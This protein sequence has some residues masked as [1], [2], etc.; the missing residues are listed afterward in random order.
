MGETQIFSLEHC[1][2]L[3]W[4]TFA[5]MGNTEEGAGLGEGKLRLIF[6]HTNFEVS[7]RNPRAGNRYETGIQEI[8]GAGNIWEVSVYNLYLKQ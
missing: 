4:K 3:S 7:I 5:E 1:H 6:Q 2:L 8:I